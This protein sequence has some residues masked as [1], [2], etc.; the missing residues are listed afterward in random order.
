MRKRLEQRR[1]L[2]VLGFALCISWTFAMMGCVS[3]YYQPFTLI[4]FGDLVYPE[5]A[6]QAQVTG[7]V[8]VKYDIQVDGTVS[9]VSVVKAAPPDVFDA[10]A[11]RYV[12]TWVFRPAKK[13]GTPQVT[14]NVES[15]ITFKLS[16]LMDDPPDY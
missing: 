2:I 13:N 8:T 15:D 3:S 11:V 10:E 4:S 1:C 16:D 12:Q 6:K 5:K 7:T 14:E 9:N